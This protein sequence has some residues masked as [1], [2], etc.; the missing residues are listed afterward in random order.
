MHHTIEVLIGMMVLGYLI[1]LTCT[2]ILYYL[3]GIK[4]EKRIWKVERFPPPS[5]EVGLWDGR[6]LIPPIFNA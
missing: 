3:C 2:T 1:N 5:L 6:G 4:K